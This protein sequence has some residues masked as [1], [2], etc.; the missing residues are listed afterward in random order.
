MKRYAFWF[1]CLFLQRNS[2]EAGINKRLS[3]IGFTKLDPC[4]KAVNWDA[5]TKVM[6]SML[7]LMFALNF[8]LLIFMTKL[9]LAYVLFPTDPGQARAQVARFAM[10][11][12]VVYGSVIVLT[13]L[14]KNRWYNAA[15]TNTSHNVIAAVVSYFVSVVCFSM[16]FSY[17][18][19]GRHELSFA[20]LLY[21]FNQFVLAYFVGVYLDRLRRGDSK[22]I[23]VAFA[24][25]IVQFLV[26]IIAILTYPAPHLESSGYFW[27][28]A[29]FLAGQSGVSGF[30]IGVLFQYVYVDPGD[31]SI[32]TR[33][34]TKGG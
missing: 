20:P 30:L 23:L 26:N 25:G 5:V 27:Y 16:W 2:E 14:L 3:K 17:F 29:C 6:G 1:R 32:G 11:F 31:K 24:Q 9:E 21:A 13:I 19:I 28:V 10:L 18:V 8:I 34:A 7:M 22:S 12:S 33:P 15:I 4:D